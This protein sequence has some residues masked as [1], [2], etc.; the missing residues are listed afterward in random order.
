[1]NM[2]LTFYRSEPAFQEAIDAC[3]EILGPHLGCDLREILYPQGNDPEAAAAKLKDTRFQQPAIFAIEYALS[4]LWNAWGIFPDAMLGHSIGEFVAATIASIFTL[5]DAL[6]L[7]AERGR[8]MSELPRGAM[9][10]VRLP[11]DEVQKRLPPGIALAASN[12]PSL[13]VVA[14]TTE[15]IAA[16]CAELQKA[17]ISCKL[18]ETSHAFHSEMMDPVVKPFGQRVAAV[19]RGSP[20]IAILSTLTTQW[21]TPDD[22]SDPDYWARHLRSPVRFCEAIGKIWED[23]DRVLLEVGPGSQATS[24]ARQQAK[25]PKL[26]LPIPSLGKTAA[27]QAEWTAILRA[28]G[29]LWLAG[30]KIDWPKLWGNEKRSRIAL[31]AY[32]FARKRYWV[33]PPLVSSRPTAPVAAPAPAAWLPAEEP[34]ARS[35]PLAVGRTPR[36]GLAQRLI[37]I[38]EEISG[39]EFGDNL[40]ETRTFAEMGLDSLFFTQISFMLRKEFKAEV[41]FRQLTE[42]LNCLQKLARHLEK[43]APTAQGAAARPAQVAT[44]EG[45]RQLDSEPRRANSALGP[46]DHPLFFGGEAELYGICHVPKKRNDDTGVLFCY[47]IAQEYMRSFWAFKLLSNLLLAK[48][49]PVFKFDYFGTGDSLGGGEDWDLGTW[50]DNVLT[51]AEVLRSKAGVRRVAVVALRFGAAPAVAAIDKGLEVSDL[52]LWD[53]VVHGDKY[54]AGLRKIQRVLVDHEK[55]LFPIPTEQELTLDPHELVGFHFRPELQ[56]AIEKFTLLQYA[57]TGCARAFL[58]V[59]DDREEYRSLQSF[60]R[61]RRKVCELEVVKDQGNWDQARHWEVG[62]LPS[63]IMKAIAHCIARGT[64]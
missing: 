64:E 43:H 36:Q 19:R 10:S 23:P 62:L 51:A 28:L 30:V 20:R 49:L 52:V 63:E 27:D 44:A 5:E 31:P 60:L 48:G 38:L 57:Y 33:D 53:P 40:D 55:Y 61:E 1:V 59:T 12:A 50:T 32:P 15:K 56:K 47:P 39:T 6:G 14:G 24:L 21:I 26:H 41:T 34:A 37:E 58:C 2:G 18:L 46:G 35:G 22:M 7:I 29:G 11:A 42:E 8:L 45:I 25:D 4:K 16:L 17:K 54:L 13:C 9:L 3:A